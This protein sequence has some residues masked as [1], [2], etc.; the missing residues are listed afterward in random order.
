M[1]TLLDQQRALRAALLRQGADAKA[2]GVRDA[3]RAI[4]VYRNNVFGNLTDALRLTYPAIRRLVGDAFFAQAAARFIADQPPRSA[5]LYEYG[6]EF[7][8]FLEGYG[9][10][11]AL[12][13][14]ADVARLE[15]AVCRALHAPRAAPL[16]AGG[17]AA[18]CRDAPETVRFAPHPALALLRLGTPARGIWRGALEP[19]EAERTARLGAIDPAS[20][21]ENLAVVNPAGTVDILVLDAAT[22]VLAERLAAGMPLGAALEGAAPDAAAARLALLVASGFLAREVD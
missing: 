8:T 11:R 3:A 1:P 7:A 6:R 10:T 16:D 13:Y 4:A 17:L 21:G 2:V 5:D 15:F 14:L 22:H 18:L 9:P 12:P 20:G 19:E